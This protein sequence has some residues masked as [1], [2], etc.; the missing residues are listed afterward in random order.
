MTTDQKWTW[1]TG[2]GAVGSLLTFIGAFLPWVSA[3]VPFAGSVSWS[4]M[5]GDGRI[6]L[7]LSII[8]FVILVWTHMKRDIGLSVIA[9]L[10]GAAITAT[11]IWKIVRLEAL[12]AE[13]ELIG[14]ASVGTGIYLS[15]IG[16]IA[17]IAS[18][19]WLA[20]LHHNP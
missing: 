9:F 12:I 18:A 19:C 10:L 13:T 6:T 3:S 5:E 15:L 8:V 17:I 7:V 16:G 11:M 2:V 20:Y 4:G 1:A 14:L